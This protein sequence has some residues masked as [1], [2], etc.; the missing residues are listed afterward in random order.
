MAFNAAGM[1]C[2]AVGPTKLYIYSTADTLTSVANRMTALTTD[3]CPGMAA[4]DV[5]IFASGT[6][7]S[8]VSIVRVVAINSTG[9]TLVGRTALA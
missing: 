6:A 1:N 4:G 7:T 3:S 8:V 5:I 9:A 2:I